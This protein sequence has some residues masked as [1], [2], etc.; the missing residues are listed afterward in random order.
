MK[1]RDAVKTAVECMEKEMQKLAF[2]ANM[3][4]MTG[5]GSPYMHKAHDRYVS[6]TDAIKTLQQIP[7]AM[8]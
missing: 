3:V 4:K 5:S 7:E 2:D 6:I 8:L 1:T